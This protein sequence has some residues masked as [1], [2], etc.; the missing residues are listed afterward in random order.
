MSMS[1]CGCGIILHA[2]RKSAVS[3]ALEADAI[4]NL[5]IVAIVRTAPLSPGIGSF[6]ERKMCALLGI[7]RWFCGGIPRQHVRRVPYHL[8]CI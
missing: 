4:T 3:L 6:L 1:V 7:V 5:M 2:V 8:P